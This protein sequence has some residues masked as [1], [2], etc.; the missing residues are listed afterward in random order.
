MEEPYRTGVRTAVGCSTSYKF[1]VFPKLS[2]GSP[3]REKFSI[4]AHCKFDNFSTAKKVT[5][6]KIAK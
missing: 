3:R 5:A 1:R 2:E 4:K 6:H